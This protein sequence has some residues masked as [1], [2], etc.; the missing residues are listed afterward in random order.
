MNIGIDARMISATGIGRY[1]QSLI[2]KLAIYDEKNKYVVFLKSNDFEKLNLPNN[3]KK[4]A[5]N[6]HWYGLV[7]QIKFPTLIK[8]NKIDLMHFPHFNI[9]IFYRGKFVVTIHDLTLHKYRT[10]KATTKSYLTYYLKHLLYKFVMKKAIYKSEKI[11]CPSSSTKKDVLNYFRIKEDKIVVTLEGGPSEKI[12]EIKKEQKITNKLNIK[13]PFLLYV[14]NAYPH[15]NLDNLILAMNDINKRYFLVLAGKEDDFYYKVKEKTINLNLEERVFFTG[16][17]SDEELVW[18]YKNASLYVFPSFNE[19]FG[20]PLLEAAFFGLPVA[21]SKSSSLTEVMQEAAIYFDP[22]SPEDIAKKINNGLN[23]NLLL[24][25]LKHK[26][27]EQLN[28]FSWDKMAKTT[29]DNY[30]EIIQK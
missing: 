13:K 2:E 4:V 9:P 24:E 25:E 3:F 23:N 22:K 16:F 20:L 26:G 8:K 28:K 30:N 7:E 17:V 12:L 15:K 18:L 1:T 6:F 5:A 19:G 10:I 21:C 14:G 27:F 29:L 11:F